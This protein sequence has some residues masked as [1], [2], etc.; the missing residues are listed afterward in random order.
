MMDIFTPL[1]GSLNYVHPILVH[2]P[3]ALLVASWGLDIAGRRWPALHASGWITLLLGALATVPATISGLIAHIPYEESSAIEAIEN[4]QYLAFATTAFFLA[5]AFWR[6]RALRRGTELGGG[7]RYLGLALLG[8]LLLVL[9]GANGGYLVYELG[10]GV[11][12][13]TPK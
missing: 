11:E 12:R 8:L 4:H 1:L 9:T 5:L 6:W 10:L 2:F 3:I 7:G 13:L